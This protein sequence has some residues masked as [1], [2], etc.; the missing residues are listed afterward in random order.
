MRY[1]CATVC[2]RA[3][4]QKDRAWEKEDD[5]ERQWERVGE[6]SNLL[7]HVWADVC[8]H[9]L[10]CVSVYVW[11]CLTVSY[12]RSLCSWF[13][14]CSNI[15][16]LI[17]WWLQE[18]L[19]AARDDG[20]TLSAPSGGRMQQHKLPLC[21]SICACTKCVCAPTCCSGVSERSRFLRW[22]YNTAC[23]CGEATQ[24]QLHILTKIGGSQLEVFASAKSNIVHFSERVGRSLGP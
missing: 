20:G 2:E 5:T 3:N 18:F 4:V 9:I 23:L 24:H 14:S 22:Q 12:H 1:L 10:K 13:Y 17:L 8:G 19:S 11:K 16:R 7:S 15:R 21:V 6:W